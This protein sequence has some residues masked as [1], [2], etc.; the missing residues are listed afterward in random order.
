VNRTVRRGWRVR[1]ALALVACAGLL[2]TV[3]ALLGAVDSVRDR[4]A[5]AAANSRLDYADRDVAWGNGWTLSQAALYAARSLV[6][7]RATYEVRLGPESEFADPL[8]FP[9]A[10]SYLRY[11]LL[12]RLPRGG[13]RWVICYRC[14][15]ESLGASA[16][17]LWEDAAAGVSIIDREGQV[18]Q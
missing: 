11:W 13:S 7:K 2:V 14:D 8:T 12:P 5:R 9:Y 1:V 17:V 18:V 16:H 15:R 10:P 6:P 3:G 4:G